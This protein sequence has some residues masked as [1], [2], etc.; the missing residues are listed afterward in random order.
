MFILHGLLCLQPYFL[1]FRQSV[2][3]SRYLNIFLA[4]PA[5]FGIQTCINILNYVL[6]LITASYRLEYLT[7]EWFLTQFLLLDYI[8]LMECSAQLFFALKVLSRIA[9]QLLL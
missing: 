6:Y 7:E 2:T 8:Q 4:K 3:F 1:L 5:D 9:L